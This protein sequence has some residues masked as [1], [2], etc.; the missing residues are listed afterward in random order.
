VPFYQVWIETHFRPSWELGRARFWASLVRVEVFGCPTCPA[1][2]G[3]AI[4]AGK[5][6]KCPTFGPTAWGHGNRPIIAEEAQ[7]QL[8]I[9]LVVAI[10][11]FS[12]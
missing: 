12:Y 3:T 5:V 9:E 2:S 4:T 6:P 11:Y 1:D 10:I 7:D 8:A